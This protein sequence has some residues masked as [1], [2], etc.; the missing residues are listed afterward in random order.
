MKKD[1]LAISPAA[2][3]ASNHSVTGMVNEIVK[4]CFFGPFGLPILPCNGRVLHGNIYEKGITMYNHGI[5]GMRKDNALH[6]RREAGN[7]PGTFGAGNEP[8]N[9]GVP[10][11]CREADLDK[12]GGEPSR[13]GPVDWNSRRRTNQAQDGQDSQG[14]D[15]E[16]MSCRSYIQDDRPIEEE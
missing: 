14:S 3:L 4:S 12:L 1:L 10:G 16:G 11:R 2:S 8:C 15:G 13:D 7:L 5:H 9:Q 6:Q